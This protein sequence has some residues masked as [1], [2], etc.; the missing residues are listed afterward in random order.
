MEQTLE[1]RGK[2]L[3]TLTDR[4][5]LRLDGVKEVLSF[6]ENSLLL[7]GGVGLLQILGGDLRVQAL[8]S[9]RGEITVHGRIDGLFYQT[10]DPQGQKSLR[11]LLRT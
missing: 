9:G 11:K 5:E 1:N 7:S 10:D 3:L 6:D 8:D 2:Q 4:R